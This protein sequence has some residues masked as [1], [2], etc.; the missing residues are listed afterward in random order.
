MMVIGNLLIPTKIPKRIYVEACVAKRASGGSGS[1]EVIN[2][3]LNYKCKMEF[4][5][6]GWTSDYYTNRVEGSITDHEGNETY[7]LEGHYTDEIHA[8]E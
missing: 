4:I 8:V 3:T 7:K 6:R 5:A 2:E 1:N